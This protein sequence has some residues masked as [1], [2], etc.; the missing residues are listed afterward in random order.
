MF[1]SR[2]FPGEK[3]FRLGS[4]CTAAIEGAFHKG[5][6]KGGWVDGGGREG[7]R[8]ACGERMRRKNEGERR[9]RNGNTLCGC[10]KRH[11]VA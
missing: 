7:G 6:G 4:V 8:T 5:V 2:M 1:Q 9:G 11:T 3:R 10:L